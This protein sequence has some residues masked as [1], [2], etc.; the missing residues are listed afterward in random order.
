MNSPKLPPLTFSNGTTPITKILTSPKRRREHE[1]TEIDVAK[2][3]KGPEG[4]RNMLESVSSPNFQLQCCTCR[5]R[6]CSLQPHHQTFNPSK[7]SIPQK[8][9]TD[10]ADLCK[11]KQIM[12]SSSKKT[13]VLAQN[14]TK[15]GHVFHGRGK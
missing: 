8:Q 7:P 1:I 10:M 13:P 3:R 5:P 2:H 14:R 15:T 4:P 11:A 6:T 9:D 12:P